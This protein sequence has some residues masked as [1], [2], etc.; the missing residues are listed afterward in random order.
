M[1]NGEGS[2]T[3]QREMDAMPPLSV[4]NLTNSAMLSDEMLSPFITR[5]LPSM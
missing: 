1:P 4:W 2:S 3:S 5:N